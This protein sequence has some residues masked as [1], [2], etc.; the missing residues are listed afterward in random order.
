MP[1]EYV[2]QRWREIEAEMKAK[3]PSPEEELRRERELAAHMRRR[4]KRKRS[5]Y[6]YFIRSGDH[7]KIGFSSNVRSRLNTIRTACAEDTF[8]CHVVPGTPRKE[9]VYHKRFAQYRVRGEWFELK[10]QLAKYLE[11]YVSPI[12]LPEPIENRVEEITL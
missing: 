8:V 7:V 11:R 5:G 1:S 10:G 6:V 12:E 4:E 3:R 2:K 9:R